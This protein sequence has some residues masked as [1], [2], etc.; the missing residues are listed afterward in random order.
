MLLA[1]GLLSPAGAQQ[2]SSLGVTPP[3]V[4]VRDAQ[5]GE[6]YRQAVTVQN[7][8]DSPTTV[9]YTPAGE[10]GGWTTATPASGFV[11]PARSSQAIDV[12]VRIPADAANG[13][14][15]G[16]LQLVA[17]PK[18]QPNGSGFALRYA[19]AVVLNI[20]VGGVQN[21]RLVWE[22]AKA[23]DVEVG[24]P[25]QVSVRVA[26]AGN[27]RTVARATAQLLDPSGQAS[28][29]PAA[30]SA[31]VV[32]G[33]ALDIPFL[34]PSALARL[35]SH[36]VRVTSDP[37]GAFEKVVG[38]DVKD[39][40]A[41]GKDGLLRFLEHEPWVDA[42]LPVKVTAVFENVGTTAIGRAKFSA[43]VTLDGKLVG[44]LA[45]EELRAAPGQVLNLSAFFTP[46]LPGTY[47]VVGKVTYDGIESPPNESQVNVRGAGTGAAGPSLGGPPLWLL[48]V[49][50]AVV[51][52]VGVAVA[53]RA[54]RKGRRRAP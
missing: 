51:L 44:V 27:V 3:Q 13:L 11:V 5:R 26:N 21:V 50:L 40:G 43:E 53:V 47:R 39:V 48:G 9:T 54:R 29:A 15:T 20:T 42:G 12:A 35:G 1:A 28:G 33:E 6:V 37:P 23:E 52:A 22:D 49:L 4:E 7:Q 18:Q 30:A 36:Q 31:E 32:P 38:F 8:F 25:A 14:H 45:S 16:H 24:S 2:P 34:F 41:L 19:V 46:A 17:E 10:V